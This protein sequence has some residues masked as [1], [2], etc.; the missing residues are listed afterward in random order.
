MD[1]TSY[2]RD[3]SPVPTSRYQ[4]AQQTEHRYW[5]LQ[6]RRLLN[7]EAKY[8]FYAGH[9]EWTRH[10]VLLNPFCVRD[11]SPG[12]FQIPADEMEGCLVLDVGC[13]PASDTLSLVHCASVCAVDPLLDVYREMQPFGWE[14]FKT[15]ASVGAEELPFDDGEFHF[16]Y[17]RNVLDHTQNA[18][19]VLREIA[20]VL[21]PRGQLLLACDARHGRGG[22]PPHPYAWS[23]ETLETR[24][25]GQF[26]PVT[27]ITLLDDTKTPV[28]REQ[29]RG[30]RVRW[31]CRVR[32]KTTPL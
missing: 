21:H 4:Q 1:H 12:N 32:R 22:G 24:V 23:I 25:F 5:S 18:D 8:Y 20:R 17:C 3:W 10:R 7:L 29:S 19:E 16:A 14:F 26:E 13:G 15:L 11:S 27:P 28:G 2:I 30:Q 9:Y 31:V 6:D